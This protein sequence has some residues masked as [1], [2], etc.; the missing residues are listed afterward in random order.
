MAQVVPRKE[1]PQEAEAKQA[2]S[3]YDP[4]TPM[5]S[6]K[7]AVVESAPLNVSSYKYAAPLLSLLVAPPAVFAPIT[8]K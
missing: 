7:L 3:A 5:L 2:L 1:A 4:K 8:R 6:I